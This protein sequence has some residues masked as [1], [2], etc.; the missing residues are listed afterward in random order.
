MK[1]GAMERTAIVLTAFIMVNL[2]IV[3]CSLQNA[4]AQT[5]TALVLETPKE[6]SISAGGMNYYQV[7]A[8]GAKLTVTL[9]GPASGADFDLY[10]KAGANPTLS[11]YDARGYTSSAD[12]T[13]AITNPS[14]TYYI[15]VH[16][17]SGSG[18]YTV[19][20]SLTSG[21]TPTTG[22]TDLPVGQT[23]SGSITATG[24]KL[25]YKTTLSASATSLVVKLNGPSGTD[26]DLYVKKGAQPTTSSYD[27]R[28]Y[29]STSVETCTINSPTAGTFYTMVYAYSGTGSFTLTATTSGGGSTT[30]TTAPTLSSI[31]ATKTS[32][33]ITVTWTTNEP[34]TSQIKYGTSTSYGMTTALDT[35]L[36]TSHSVTL[37]GLLSST[38]YHYAVMSKDAAGN[39]ATSTDRTATTSAAT[40][41]TTALTL[42]QLASGT[43]S[44]SGG[45]AYYSVAVTTTASK[46]VVTL[47]GPTGTDFDL[48]VKLGSNPTTSSYTVK[49]DT[50]SPDEVATVNNPSTGTYYIMIKAYSGTGAYTIK[51]DLVTEAADTT[52]PVVSITNPAAGATVSGTVSITISA[53]D[54]SGI[55][56]YQILID[57]VSKSTSSSYSWN[58]ASYANGAHTILAKAKDTAGN[59]GEKT[60]TVTVDNAAADTTAPTIS[61]IAA[62]ATSSSITVTWTTNEPATSQVKYGTS[63]SYGMTTTLDT[64]LVT[65]HSV[66]ISGLSASTT[67]HYQVLSKDAAANLGTSAD[68]TVATSAPPVSSGAKWTFIV[69]L[70]GDN[71]LSSFASTDLNE[72]KAVGSTADVN[73]IVLYDRSTNGDSKLYKVNSGSLQDLGLSTAGFTG[74]ELNMGDPNVFVKFVKWAITAY[75]AE[76]Y[77]IDFWNHGGGW[78]GICWDDSASGAYISMPELKSAM[79]SIVAGNGGNKID[80][81]AF[82]A[83]LMAQLEVLSQL[84][85]YANIAVA[86][87]KTEPGDGW[88]YTP[89]LQALTSTPSMTPATLATKI[90]TEYY[91]DYNGG[92][93]SITQAAIDLTKLDAVISAVDTLATQLKNNLGSYQTQ[94]GNAINGAEQYDFAGYRDLYHL[95]DKIKSYVSVSAVQTAASAVQSAISAC[96]ISE[97]H[98]KGGSDMAVANAHGITINTNNDYSNSEY[99]ATALCQNTQW[100]EFLSSYY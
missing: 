15:M 49:A 20:A 10:V 58:T 61:N 84:S 57:G 4:N 36:V 81:V 80:I 42:G 68:K 8:T 70:D 23:G 26:F 86:S 30:D 31:A 100:N 53:T 50:S 93:D 29:T 97:K 18:S 92:S 24:Q 98:Y 64:S 77:L 37:T 69:Y 40:P 76:H 46:L 73:I 5:A 75:P 27:V 47:D 56:S 59:W 67:Y 85:P 13:V 25:Y 11:S 28:G 2:A 14:G 94:I 88:P 48:Y 7:A 66:S 72:M 82:D 65:S 19:K 9:D 45:T 74:T 39:L 35:T 54:A 3:V 52:A 83:C 33:T 6:G 71:S 51:A 91:N 87:E 38:T 90:V 43:I 96:V 62:T 16:A 21:T 32:S 99:S 41:T 22:E 79:A 1:Y 95:C 17:Y 63:T 44:T 78:Q 60:I 12:E 89:I 55:S 34:A